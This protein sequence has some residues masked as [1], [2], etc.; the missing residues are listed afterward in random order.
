MEVILWCLRCE[1]CDKSEKEDLL[2]IVTGIE[3]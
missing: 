3:Y 1:K 2:G